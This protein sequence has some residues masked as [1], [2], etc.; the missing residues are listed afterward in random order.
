MDYLLTLDFTN[1]RHL[2]TPYENS[3]LQI[4]HQHPYHAAHLVTASASDS[5]PLL[6]VR[7]L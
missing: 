7:A 4:A 5:V 6:N 2:Q 3:L 1:F